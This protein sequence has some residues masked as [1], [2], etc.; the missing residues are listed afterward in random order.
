MSKRNDTREGGRKRD[1]DKEKGGED[2]E[3]I[4]GGRYGS[5]REPRERTKREIDREG[6]I[7]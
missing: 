4:G 7:C 1:R 3:Q 6:K 5:E 2:Y